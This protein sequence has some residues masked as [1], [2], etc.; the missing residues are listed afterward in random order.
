MAKRLDANS[1]LKK[2]QNNA[3]NSVESIK[4]GV[5]AVTT[6]PTQQAAASADLWQQRVSSQSA[7]D[8]FTSNLQK[9]S[10]QDWKTAMLNKGV[11]NYTNG[12]REGSQKMLK[13][14]NDFLPVAAASADQVSTMP[15][16]TEQA[17]IDR[18][19]ANMRNMK[20]FRKS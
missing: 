9:V 20:A 7:K 6:A 12:V 14:L 10:L 5:N 2:W 1:V 3:Q 4:T 16:G 13:F 8:K 11:N 19:V 15:K 17:S 18:F